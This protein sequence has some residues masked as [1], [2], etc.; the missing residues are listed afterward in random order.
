MTLWNN[1]DLDLPAAGTKHRP[2]SLA[3]LA[4]AR[5]A[6]QGQFWTPHAVSQWIGR[7]I[8]P[9]LY[10][11]AVGRVPVVVDPAVGCG[12]LLS[13]LDPRS[14]NLTGVDIDDR[15]IAALDRAI[16]Q[17]RWING[18]WLDYRVCGKADLALINPPFSLTWDRPG[19][20]VPWGAYGRH[21]PHSSVL[22]H[23]HLIRDA[24]RWAATVVAI[25]P[26]SQLASF[27]ASPADLPLVATYELPVD[28]FVSEGAHVATAVMVFSASVQRQQHTKL[29][30]ADLAKTPVPLRGLRFASEAD[31]RRFAIIH[32]TC[33]GEPA[34]QTPVTGD[35]H[36]R[37]YR[38]GRW[39][40]LHFACGFTEARVRNALLGKRLADLDAERPPGQRPHR[41][42]GLV[43]SAEGFLDIERILLQDD[44][45]EAFN[46][47]IAAITKAGGQ[48]AVDSQLVG[49]FDARLRRL[50]RD[51]APYGHCVYDR[52]VGSQTTGRT[53]KAIRLGS[54]FAAPVIP[55]DERLTVQRT[56]TGYAVAWRD[57]THHLPA[58]VVTDAIALDEAAPAW[59]EASPAAVHVC[60]EAATTIAQ[61]ARAL[62][63]DRFLTWNYQWNDLIEVRSKSRSGIIAWEMG[64]GKARLALALCLLGGR[65]NLIVVEAHLIDEMLLEVESCGIDPDDVR[66][67]NTPRDLKRLRRINLIAYSRLRRPVTTTAG[68]RTYARQLRGRIHTVVCDECHCIRHAATAQ[69]RAIW[70]LRP[71]FRYGL[72]GTPI[73]NY[74]RDILQLL[75]WTGG[76]ATASQPFSFR[77]PHANAASWQNLDRSKRSSD[78]FMDTYVTMEWVTNEFADDLESGAKREVPKL[79]NPDLFRQ[80]IAPFVKRRLASEPEVRKYLSIPVPATETITLSWDERHLAHYLTIADNFAAWYRRVFHEEGKRLNLIALLAR[81]AA[82]QSAANCPDAPVAGVGA[83]YG[84]D[85]SKHRYVVHAAQDWIANDHRGIIFVQRPATATRLHAQLQAAGVD[86]LLY[87][88]AMPIAKRNRELYRRFVNG[89]VPVLIATIGSCQTGLNLYMAD[90]VL[91][92]ERSWSPK[93]EHQAAARVLRPQQRK[94]VLIQFLHLLGSIDE[95]QNQLVTQKWQAISAALDADEQEDTPFEHLDTLFEQFLENLATRRGLT[96]TELRDSITSHA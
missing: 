7:L 35:P 95:Y 75:I 10:A 94:P 53:R 38:S 90:R 6:H 22:S 65:H 89:N 21:G 12:R 52:H 82:V 43:F 25:V 39:I 54:A 55:A 85:T 74:P 81:I 50:A 24:C 60:P 77:H 29:T 1:T 71:T 28:T 27:T 80:L 45:R 47:V 91:F 30:C 4:A 11:Q 51:Q 46:V 86:A 34:V 2:G 96:R 44:P 87:H 14:A 31:T 63:I 49:Y 72:T 68:R 23:K 66:V 76:A 64:L 20:D 70:A 40:R 33:G 37:V 84:P 62:G 83:A 57:Q 61:R 69:T 3:G 36:V 93:A 13:W 56:E 5:R 58:D 48:P 41:H 32:H 9:S 78:H 88:G 15:C 8:G 17:G 26:V 42:P 92:Y 19:L 59:Q 18:D 16:P 79:R 73:A 67:I